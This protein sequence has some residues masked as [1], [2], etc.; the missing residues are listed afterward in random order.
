[1]MGTI[2]LF[3]G[4]IGAMALATALGLTIAGARAFDE[5][6]Y[7]DWKGQWSRAPVAGFEDVRNPSWDPNKIE[8]LAQQAPMTPEYQA[9]WDASLADQ[10]A[11][12]AGRDRDYVCFS[13]GMPRMMN[14]YST[15][16]ILVMPD[17][18]YILMGFLHDTRR[19]FT[20]GREWPEAIE[21]TPTGYSIG[22]WIANPDGRYEVLEV[23]TRGFRGLRTL[24]S[25][26]LPLHAD[27]QT[28]VKERFYGDKADR[29]I[30]HDDI[31]LIDHAFTHPWTVT[32]DYRRSPQARPVWR[33]SP[34]VEGNQHVRIGDDSY[35]LSADGLLMPAKKDQAPPDLRYFQPRK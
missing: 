28:I 19:I 29:N 26:G 3:R 27:N 32:K 5:T 20:D 21:P 35:M 18:T 1:M 22:K 7:P 11:G 4:S 10:R 33:E 13:P 14:V 2:M 12:G 9:V 25:T 23:E 17:T 16:E 30:L 24:D 34:C 31:T 8:G 6:K 15:M